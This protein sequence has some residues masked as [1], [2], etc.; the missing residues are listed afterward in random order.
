MA[1]TYKQAIQNNH[2]NALK[3][4]E[5]AVTI[6][7]ADAKL[8]CPVD[9]GTLKRSITHE[10]NDGGNKIIGEVGSNVEYAYWAEKHQP[11]LEPSVDKNIE[12][13]KQM[14]KQELSR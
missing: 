3:A 10:V 7:E 6:I 11:Y 13:I 12:Q 8:I 14:F 9:S 2:E 5:K 4:M 1:I